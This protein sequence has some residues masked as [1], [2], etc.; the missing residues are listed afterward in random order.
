VTDKLRIGIIG[1]GAIGVGHVNTFRANPRCELTA[2]CDQ[3]AAWIEKAKTDFG[4]KYGFTDWRGLV[5]CD[6]V[7]PRSRPVSTCCARSRWL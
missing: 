4:A 6:E 1:V 3:D 2:L 5:A 7:S